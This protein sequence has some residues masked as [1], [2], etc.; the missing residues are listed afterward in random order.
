[1]PINKSVT[2]NK[3]QIFVLSQ[4]EPQIISLAQFS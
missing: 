2:E 1:M 4:E 3:V